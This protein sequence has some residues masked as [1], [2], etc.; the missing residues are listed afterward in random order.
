ML[1]LLLN[2]AL[3]T[4]EGVEWL[5]CVTPVFSDFVASFTA[6]KNESIF[7]SR[8][9]ETRGDLAITKTCWAKLRVLISELQL[10]H[11]GSRGY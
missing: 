3:C 2:G 5:W 9:L 4:L 10:L 1:G 11:P 8:F 6:K 7:G